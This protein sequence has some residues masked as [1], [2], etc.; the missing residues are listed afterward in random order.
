MSNADRTPSICLPERSGKRG[1]LSFGKPI[2]H[3]FTLRFIDIQSA[4]IRIPG[5]SSYLFD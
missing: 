4:G 3:L 5:I 2:R 1:S